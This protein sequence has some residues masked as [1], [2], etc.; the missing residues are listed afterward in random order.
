MLI[1]R[2]GTVWP[3]AYVFPTLKASD[4]W[5]P[6]RPPVIARVSGVSGAFDYYVDDNFPL[7]P[8]DVTKTFT[9]EGSSYSNVETLR[10]ALLN[11]T[12]ALGRTK[13]WGLWRDGTTRVWTWAKCISMKAVETAAEKTS[14]LM[15]VEARFQCFTGFWYGESQKSWSNTMVIPASTVGHAVN[16]LSNDG[17]SPAFLD[18]RIVPHN[19]LI[20]EDCAVGVK[21]VSQWE[22]AGDFTDGIQLFV[23]ASLYKC[24][25]NDLIDEKDSEAIIAGSSMAVWGDRDFIF[26]CN[27]TDGIHS[28]AVNAVGTIGAVDSDDQG[29]SAQA[30]WGDG[31]FVFLANAGGGIHSYSVLSG[32]FT[33]IDSDDQGDLA[34]G[35][36]GDGQFVYLANGDGGLLVYSVSDAGVFTLE[37]S[38]DQGDAAYWVWGDGKFVYLANHA[39]GL[40]SYSVADDGT[41][42]FIDSHAPGTGPALSVW[43]DGKFIY[44]V[45]STGGLYSYSVDADGNLNPIDSDDQGGSADSVWGDGTLIYVANGLSGIS[46]YSVNAVGELT[47]LEAFDAGGIAQGV[48]GDGDFVFLANDNTLRSYEMNIETDTY[49][50]LDVGQGSL[51]SRL[52]IDQTAWLWLPSNKSL[53]HVVVDCDGGGGGEEVDVHVT[54][55]D[56]YVL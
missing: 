12:I 1:A 6:T 23:S 2:F 28:Y 24:T 48:W 36:W 18:V 46:V 50:D 26:S 15:N 45:Y 17:N 30:V 8:L 29:D 35:V 56:T 42:T 52:A 49:L 40:L 34:R 54:W 39:G 7:S 14:L 16:G 51:L 19:S 11:E 21:D 13:L 10:I 4:N 47:F 27:T 32:M 43:G 55:W 25:T 53:S 33:H 22:F 20:V 44:V 31:Q 37:D 38:D 5:V 3:T 41:L 9:L